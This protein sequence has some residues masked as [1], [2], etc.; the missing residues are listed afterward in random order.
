MQKIQK[1]QSTSHD[2]IDLFENDCEHIVFSLLNYYRCNFAF[3]L[4]AELKA[5][6]KHYF[7]PKCASDELSKVDRSY[8]QKFL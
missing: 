6:S 2:L 8:T 3:L 4:N 1:E 5:V 7:L